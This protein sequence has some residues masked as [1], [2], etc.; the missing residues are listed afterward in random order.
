MLFIPF[1]FYPSSVPFLNTRRVESFTLLQAVVLFWEIHQEK[2]QDHK[3]LFNE[4][5]FIVI[6]IVKRNKQNVISNVFKRSYLK[7]VYVLHKNM[8]NVYSTSKVIWDTI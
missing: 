4:E 6:I 7:H 5:L 1:R 8:F 3:N 2:V